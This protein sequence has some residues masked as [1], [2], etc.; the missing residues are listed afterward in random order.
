MSSP[1]SPTAKL[2]NPPTDSR[3]TLLIFNEQNRLGLVDGPNGKTTPWVLEEVSGDPDQRLRERLSEAGSRL[4][5]YFQGVV[6]KGNAVF[7]A[8]AESRE[9]PEMEWHPL[10]GL[11]TGQSSLAPRLREVINLAR[12]RSIEIPYLDFRRHDFV[13]KFRSEQQ[14]NKGIYQNDEESRRL[15]QSQLCEVIKATRRRKENRSDRPARLDFGPVVYYLPSHFGFCL[16]VQNAIERAYETLAEHPEKRVFMLSE[17]IH[18]P[19]VNEDLR[20]RGLLFLQN[21]KGVPVVNPETGAD[22]WDELTLED[23]VVIPA[24]GATIEDKRQLIEKGLELNRYDATCMLV[25]KVW[26]AA[27]RYGEAGF[28]VIIHGKAEHEETKATFSNSSRFAPCVVIRNLEEAQ[29]L[30]EIISMEPGE[31]K[32]RRFA[33]AGFRHTAGFCPEKDL[34]R[35]AVVNQT[36]LLRNETLTIITYFQGLY[37][38][39]YGAEAVGEHVNGQ[40]RGDTLCY[41]TQVNQDALSRTLEEPIDV[42]LVAGGKNS[43]NT[44]QLY[45]I[46]RDRFGKRAFYIQ[47]EGNLRSTEEVRH[48]HFPYDPAD[49]MAGKEEALPFLNGLGK[50]PGEPFR[51]LLTGG[52]SCPDGIIQQIITRIN[53]FFPEDALRSIE[54]VLDGIESPERGGDH[55]EN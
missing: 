54:S 3:A 17:L 22:F 25:E 24:F 29:R 27:K 40:S 6:A 36:T 51:I 26:K 43:S 20:R 19:F 31:E 32:R 55:H 33:V 10:E 41:A 52:A 45:R 38:E 7:F 47:S 44:F 5:P 46:C 35:I 18:N 13:Y 53:G 14:R 11:S 1:S 23:I 42:A 49:A 12:A 21:D 30:G 4:K 16:G 8:K 50:A 39:K 48:Y 34:E 9:F 15:Y 37:G 28:T 2:V